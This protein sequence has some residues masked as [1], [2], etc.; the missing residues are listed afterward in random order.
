MKNSLLELKLR[1]WLQ[2]ISI[3][4][5]IC[6]YCRSLK[7]QKLCSAYRKSREKPFCCKLKNDKVYDFHELVMFRSNQPNN[8]L[9][10]TGT[11]IGFQ[12]EMT[13]NDVFFTYLFLFP[14]V[15]LILLNILTF[16]KRG[17]LMVTKFLFT[18]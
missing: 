8:Q 13:L 15:L 3:A 10:G 9:L 7:M 14:F 18:K 4:K 12:S 16:L 11:S 2:E 5:N 1:T 17:C 6:E